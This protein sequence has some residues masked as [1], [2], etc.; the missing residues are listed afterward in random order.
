MRTERESPILVIGYGNTLRGDDALGPR[1]AEAVA[2]WNRPGVSVV[3]VQQLTPELA[4]PIATARLVLFLDARFVPGGSAM[5][6][7][8]HADPS[9]S[10]LGH[11][12][13]PHRLLALAGVVYA[14]VPSAWLLTL[15]AVDFSLREGLSPQGEAA[16]REALRLIDGFLTQTYLQAGPQATPPQAPSKATS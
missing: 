2:R 12:S 7:P 10:P 3:S 5:L 4:E 1:A 11:V 13:T 14:A 16:L 6:Q 15:P 9:P 8:I